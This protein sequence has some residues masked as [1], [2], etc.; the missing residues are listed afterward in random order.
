MP[1][2]FSRSETWFATLNSQLWKFMVKPFLDLM[3]V[4]SQRVL[5]DSVGFHQNLIAIVGVN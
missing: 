2:D 4:E 1:D 3:K 5:Q